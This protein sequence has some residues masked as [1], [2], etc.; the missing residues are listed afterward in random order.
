VFA[1]EASFQSDG[2]PEAFRQ[3]SSNGVGNEFTRSFSAALISFS[4]AV[5]RMCPRHV[6]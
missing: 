4:S 6:H 1:T 5:I 2:W 3:R